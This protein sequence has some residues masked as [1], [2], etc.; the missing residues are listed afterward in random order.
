M[1]PKNN[2]TVWNG[3]FDLTGQVFGGLTVARFLRIEN[4]KKIW[5]CF[6]LCGARR[7][8]STGRLNAGYT[9][10][11]GCL[12]LELTANTVDDFWGR[13]LKTEHCWEWTGDRDADGYGRFWFRGRAWRSHR[14]SWELSNGKSITSETLVLHK[15][16]NPPCIR[17]SHLFTGSVLDNTRDKMR[18]QRENVREGDQHGNA[19]LTRT[20]VE[21]IRRKVVS[22]SYSSLARDYSVSV[23]TISGIVRGFDWAFNQEEKRRRVPLIPTIVTE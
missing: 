6:C 13:C 7:E 16:D 1:M 11:C 20:Q 4:R 21:E 18:K 8:F 19:K 23:S 3:N 9:R 10:S 17:P 15:C 22:Q 12:R 14:L 2:L 5:E